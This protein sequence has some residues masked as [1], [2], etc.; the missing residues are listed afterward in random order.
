MES[1]KLNAPPFPDHDSKMIV[2]TR[3]R[4]G[5]NLADYP[6]GPGLSGPQRIEI[7]NKV[8]QALST[9]EGDLQ[10]TFYPIKGMSKEDQNKLIEDH[11]L[12]K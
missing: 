1:S 6:L 4:V 8:V 7:M 10:G 3:I 2:S 9:F 12:F 11:F 5:R